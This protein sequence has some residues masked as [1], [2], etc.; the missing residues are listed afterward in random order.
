MDSAYTRREFNALSEL[1]S[2]AMV[3]FVVREVP[4]VEESENLIRQ[5]T[6]SDLHGC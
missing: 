5:S 4:E 1:N 6:W 2:A 3:I